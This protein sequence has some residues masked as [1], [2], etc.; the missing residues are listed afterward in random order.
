MEKKKIT[1]S[2]TMTNATKSREYV[3]DKLVEFS[4]WIVNVHWI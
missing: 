3:A 4:V 1:S 2:A